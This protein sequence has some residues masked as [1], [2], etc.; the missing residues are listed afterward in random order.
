MIFLQAN[1]NRSR[2]AQD[3]LAQISL[4][5]NADIVIISEQHRDGAR[6]SWYSDELG[7]AAIW[8]PDPQSQPVAQHG[9]GKGYVWVRINDISIVSCY[10]T[11]NESIGDFQ[12]K[13]DSLEDMLRD[14]GGELIVAGDFNAKALE[15]GE[16]HPDSRG[17]RVLDMASRT[18]L[19]ILNTGSTSTFRRAGYRETIPD[20]SLATERLA[21]SVRDWRVI[22]GYTASDHQYITFRVRDAKPA[23]PKA[24]DSQIRWNI[25]KMDEEVLNLALERGQRSLYAIPDGAVTPAQAK[26]VSSITMQIIHRACEEAIPRTRARGGRRPA[27]WW[28]NE[29]AELR[30]K[31]LKLRRAAQRGRQ[32]DRDF[33]LRS[34]EYRTAKKSLGRA[35]KTSKRRCWDRLKDDLNSDPWGL[36]YKIVMRKLGAFTKSAPMEAETMD[37]IVDTLFPAHPKRSVDPEMSEDL[38][39]PPFTEAELR[40]AAGALKNKKA[41]GPDGLPAEVLKAV[42]RSHPDLLLNMYNSCLRAGVFYSRWKEARLVLISKGKGP[43]DAPSSY[44]PLC[45]LDT[46]GKLLEKLVRPRLQAAIRAAGDLSERQYG[47]RTGRSTIDAIQEVVKAARSTER[48][49]H[50]SRP[51]CLL[52]TL[53]VKNAFNS[54]RWVDALEAL[55]RNFRV[56]QYLLHIIGDYLRDRFIVYKTEDGLK[57]KEL[58]AGAA[59]GSI[60]GPDLWNASYDGI[61]RLEMPEGCFLIGYADDVAAVISARDVDAA[62]M[63]LGQVMSRVRRWM[64]ERGLELALTKTEI[65]LLTKKRIPRLFPVQVGEV[66]AGTK[67][68]IRYLGVMLDTKLTFWDQIRKG[69]DKAAEVTASLSRMM[70]N[71]GGPR[72]CVRRL[73]LRTAESIMLYGAEIWA[74]AMRYEKYRKRLSAVQRRGALRV[75]SSYRTVSEPAVLVIAGV[76]PVDLLAQGRKFVHEME[77]TLGRARSREVAKEQALGAWQR[78]WMEDTRGRWTAKLI[79][80]LSTWFNR[81]HGEVNYYLTQMLTGHGLFCAYLHRMGKVGSP[82]CRYCGAQKDDALHTFFHCGRWVLERGRIDEALGQISPDNIVGVMLQCERNWTMVAGFVQDVLLKKKQDMLNE[83]G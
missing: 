1:L 20:V 77:G 83:A 68:A 62:Q 80:E 45:M 49:N 82:Q 58:T 40:R 28:T 7:T 66:T 11:P 2:T 6:T 30:K 81:R 46:A 29:I 25:R 24:R 64:S 35:I 27:Y 69:A 37:R 56:P 44:R 74:D 39:V 14:I 67:A 18:G 23:R 9:S 17:G 12:A 55:K 32:S 47:F 59:Q 61:L 79:G 70:A 10:L 50:F 31:C 8:I 43:A 78:R 26:V 71:I 34:A 42:A 65:V 72:P 60:L 36:G 53:D 5:K 48:G 4:E 52:V 57:R 38:E 15:W 41:P 54:V 16:G 13:M 33:A 76:I 63:R 21:A 51:V 22:E 75:T 3:L 19:V 73:L